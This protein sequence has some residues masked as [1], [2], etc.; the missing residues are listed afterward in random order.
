MSQVTLT[1]AALTGK[2]ADRV[3][4]EVILSVVMIAALTAL[5]VWKMEGVWLFALPG[6]GLVFGA[7]RVIL[8]ARRNAAR[9]GPS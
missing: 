9:T 5:S 4:D 2:L 1:R 7:V 8:T 6:A 3:I